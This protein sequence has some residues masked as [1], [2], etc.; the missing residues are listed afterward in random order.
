MISPRSSRGAGPAA[1]AAAVH[2]GTAAL[3]LAGR[4]QKSLEFG[5]LILAI[6]LA[7]GV[8]WGVVRLALPGGTALSELRDSAGS[9]SIAPCTG[10]RDR[11]A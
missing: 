5:L 10:C 8:I 6:A 3:F 4:R 2:R 7:A 1:K 9:V 11:P